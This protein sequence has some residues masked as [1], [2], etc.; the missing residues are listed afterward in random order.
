MCVCGGGGGSG[1][2]Y[3]Y[4]WMGPFLVL[5]VYG[6]CLRHLFLLFIIISFALQFLSANSVDLDQTPSTVAS[7][8]GL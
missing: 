3:P 5:G 7:A 6:G 8:L 2:V 1:F 4:H